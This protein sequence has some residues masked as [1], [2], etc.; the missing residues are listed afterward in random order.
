MKYRRLVACMA[1]L[2][3]AGGL[4][5]IATTAAAAAPPPAAPVHPGDWS[6]LRPPVPMTNNG[7]YYIADD[8]D[9]AVILYAPDTNP[10]QAYFSL[11]EYTW[12]ELEQTK[13][14]YDGGDTY[15]LCSNGSAHH[16]LQDEDGP[17]DVEDQ[18]ETSGQF[19]WFYQYETYYYLICNYYWTVHSGKDACMWDDDGYA[20]ATPDRA[21]IMALLPN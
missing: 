5:M 18:A 16:C 1:A 12:F 4:G 14:T 10:D 15:W 19:W 11:P 8:S 17:V 9:D 6:H 7:E 3:L 20:E 13:T 2:A 21:D